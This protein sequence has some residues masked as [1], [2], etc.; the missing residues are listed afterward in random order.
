MKTVDQLEASAEEES[1]EPSEAHD[2]NSESILQTC[3]NYMC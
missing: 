3:K 1:I 2:K